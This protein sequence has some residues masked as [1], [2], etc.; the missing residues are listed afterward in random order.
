MLI[1]QI[2]Y[3]LAAISSCAFIG[4]LAIA[5]FEHLGFCSSKVEKIMTLL[6]FT[7]GS[8]FGAHLILSDPVPPLI[9]FSFLLGGAVQIWLL[10]SQ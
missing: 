3:L 1:L 8:I 4:C 2:V 6:I 7:I 10:P 9:T 5:V